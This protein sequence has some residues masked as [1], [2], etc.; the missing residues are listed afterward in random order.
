MTIS[1]T[2][3]TP[4]T[5]S[6]HLVASTGFGVSTFPGSGFSSTVALPYSNS[7]LILDTVF[8]RFLPTAVQIYSG[9]I[10]ISGGGIIPQTVNVTGS[11]VSA[12]TILGIFVSPNGNDADSGTYGHPFLTIQKSISVAQP[13]DT[14][15]IRAGTYVNRYYN[16]PFSKWNGNS[17]NM[18][19]RISARWYTTALRLFIYVL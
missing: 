13:G 10:T 7:T 16:R 6:I 11:A 1:G 12:S 14:I 3:L 5:D 9:N 2:Y 8:I 17:K 15:F 4:V 19:Y 18:S